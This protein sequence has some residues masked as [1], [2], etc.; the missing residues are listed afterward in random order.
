MQRHTNFAGFLK[1]CNILTKDSGMP[2]VRREL[3]HFSVVISADF[4]K[5]SQINV[6]HKT[7]IQD[8]WM[9]K[10]HKLGLHF[11]VYSCKVHCL[12]EN[13][14]A[15]GVGRRSVWGPSSNW[16]LVTFSPAD[17]RKGYR[18]C[19]TW[20]NILVSRRN[21]AQQISLIKKT[22]HTLCTWCIGY[23]R[24]SLHSPLIWCLIRHVTETCPATYQQLQLHS[25]DITNKI[26]LPR[27]YTDIKSVLKSK[28]AWEEVNQ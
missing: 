9:L 8:C 25:F 5:L 7:V 23:N 20:R 28:A 14:E 21:R 3:S 12:R 22:H 2:S 27:N 1:G 6:W 13:L 15:M 24:Q 4:I 10:M 26:L 18:Q 11:M 17:N 16:I 19:R